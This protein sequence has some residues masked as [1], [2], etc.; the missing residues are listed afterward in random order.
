MGVLL[1]CRMG[2]FFLGELVSKGAPA[3]WVGELES[4]RAHS[5]KRSW[6]SGGSVGCLDHESVNCLGVNTGISS[7]PCQ[8]ILEDIN[9]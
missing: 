1:F 5:G 4:T 2:R 7:N 3:C 6:G 9:L 8:T